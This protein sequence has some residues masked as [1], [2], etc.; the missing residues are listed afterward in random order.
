M[1]HAKRNVPAHR[2]GEQPA[3]D[4]KARPKG[5]TVDSWAGRV[6]VEWDPE[7]PLTP[8]GQASFFIEFLKASGVFDALVADC[9]L[10][11]TS[12]NAPNK[13]D[14]LGTAVLSMLSGHKRYAHM[15]ALR[16]DGVLPELLG[17]TRV[18]SE[19]AV[20]RGLKAIPES[21]GIRW[22]SSHLD[23]C[24]T[25]LL[26][27]DWVL[28]ADTTIKPLYGHQEG[29]ELG[30]NPK[31][32]GRPSHVYHSYMLANVRLVLD[33]EVMP[34]NKHTSNH[35]VPGLWALLDR[36]GRDCWPT[37]LRGDKSF[38]SDAMM[39][40]C[41]TRGLRYL[42][43]LR[44]TNNVK[45]AIERM[46][47]SGG[48]KT[49]GQGWEGINERLQLSGWSRARRVVLL[50]RRI[51]EQLV[52]NHRDEITGQLRLSFAQI[53]KGEG[54]RVRGTGDFARCR[55]HYSRPALSRQ[56]GL[57]EYLR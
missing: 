23:Y 53:D 31:K 35:S 36:I 18:M 6:H 46:A 34:G 3:V 16:A 48:W 40:E 1:T 55:D 57:R 33:V 20:R 32:P 37:L 10:D 7:A 42:L 28:D 27:E 52:H 41:E 15:A 2:R 12:P 25:P 22:L 38:S 51:K 30:Y 13:R 56:S 8:L 19:D 5:V 9:P 45:R 50:R 47:G 17:L 11:Y 39:S 54:L 49:A 29:A 24:T 44:L 21:A 43:R 26:G 4:R 14:V